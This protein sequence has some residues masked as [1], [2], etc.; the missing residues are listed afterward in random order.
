MRLFRAL[1]RRYDQWRI[2]VGDRV[3]TPKG[4]GTVVAHFPRQLLRKPRCLVVDYGDRGRYLQERA[5][6]WR[7]PE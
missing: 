5:A 6:C 2:R 1:R 7:A 4:F 3:G